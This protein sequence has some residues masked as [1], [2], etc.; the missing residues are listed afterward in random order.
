[1]HQCGLTVLEVVLLILR[2]KVGE[3]SC[4]EVWNAGGGDFQC[5]QVDCDG[6]SGTCVRCSVW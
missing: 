3:M 2:R 4:L 6:L 1:V 5:R